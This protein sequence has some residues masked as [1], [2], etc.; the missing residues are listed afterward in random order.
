M[1]VDEEQDWLEGEKRAWQR[2]S[3]LTPASVCR[4]AKADYNEA[5]GHYVLP[6]FNTEIS[7]SPKDRSI[8]GH[9]GTADMLLNELSQYSR[10]A[11]LCYL[12]GAKDIPLSGNLINPR[13]LSGGQMFIQGSHVLPL[14]RIVA[15]YSHDVNAFVQRGTNFGSEQLAYGDTSIRLMP[16]PRVPVVLII[17]KGDGEFPARAEILFDANCSQH[18]STDI[19]WAT[20]MMSIMMMLT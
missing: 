18:L 8:R 14:D 17:W 15:R 3:D 13:Q 16:F 9:S 19:I 6:L 2:L 10:L 11:S 1:S 5:S 20:A 12:S 4:N 7:I